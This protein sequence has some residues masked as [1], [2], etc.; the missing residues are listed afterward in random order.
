MHPYT[1]LNSQQFLVQTKQIRSPTHAQNNLPSIATQ[2][3]VLWE[4]GQMNIN[5]DSAKG[6]LCKNILIY[7]YCKYENKG[8]AFSHRRNNNA[9]LGPGATPAKSVAT[10]PT[11]DKRKFNVNTPSFQPSTAPVQGLANK[12]AGLLPKVK[13]IPVFVP[14]GTPASPAQSTPSTGNQEQPMPTSTVSNV[15]ERKFNTSTPSFTPSQPIPAPPPQNTSSPPTNPYLMNQP[16]PPTDMYY[17]SA[18]PLQYHLYA[19]APPPRLAITHSLHQVDAHSLFIDSE[20]RETLQKRNEA[21]LQ[22]YPGGP[23]IVD[24]YHTVVPIAAEGVSKIWKVSSSVYKGV[25]NVDGNVYALRKI[26]DFKII[27]ETPFR[28]IKRWHGL[29][30][31]NIVKIQDAFTTVAFGSPSLVVAYDYYPNAS[32]LLEQHVNRRLG[33]RL[34]PLTEDILWLYLTQLVNA[35]RTVHK[36]K[37]AARSSLDLSKIIV[38]TNRIR[39]AAIGMSDILNWEADDAEI[40]RVGLPTYMENLQQEDIRN[41]ARLMVDLTTVMN[42][43]VQNDIFKLKSSG[44]STDFVAAV[45]DLSNTDDLESYIRKHLAIRLLD[46]VDMLEDLNDYLESQLST[47]LEN[48]RL[49]RLMTK[50]NFI[51]DRPEWD[52]EATAAAAGWT[53]NGPKYLLK[54]FRDF[55]FFQTDEM[56]KPV[57]DLSRVLVTLNKLDAGIDEKF[58]LVSRDEKTCIVV[59]YK[60]IRDLLESVFRTITRGK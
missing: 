33:G 42:P 15:P 47:E 53:E 57:T 32:T 39:L 48:A 44:L 36:K 20:L 40:A 16:G 23:E 3:F 54:L 24:V 22:S 59:S 46:V 18:Y 49:V 19:P 55:V 27:N 4:H 58:L 50:I 8:C 9:N 34:E 41:M 56:G 14:S 21:T 38:T 31:A 30:S 43:V 28:T 10:T 52:N 17:Q 25:S 51:V 5:L 6:T 60:E 12:F 11:S 35:V 13:D 7:G 2:A 1:T 29:Q 45:Q 26:E 37:L